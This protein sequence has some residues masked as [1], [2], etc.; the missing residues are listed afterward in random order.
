MKLLPIIA[1]AGALMVSGCSQQVFKVNGTDHTGPERTSNFVLY[2]IAQT[3]IIDA[4][5]IC[6]GASKIIS[7]SQQMTVMNGLLR[8]VTL[9]IYY[10]RHYR[11]TCAS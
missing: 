11:V 5:G 9:N 2:G 3:D 4:A 7:V 6:G 8:F 1:L 10:P